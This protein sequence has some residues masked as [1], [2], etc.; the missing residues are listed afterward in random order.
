M[1]FY[2]ILLISAQSFERSALEGCVATHHLKTLEGTLL[3]RILVIC[4]YCLLAHNIFCDTQRS[5]RPVLSTVLGTWRRSE[6][7]PHEAHSFIDDRSLINEE[8]KLNDKT[9][10]ELALL[11]VH[12]YLLLLSIYY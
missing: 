12:I 9:L 1:D 3:L 10:S 2:S 5:L 6:S 8:I 11:S 4:Y 7:C